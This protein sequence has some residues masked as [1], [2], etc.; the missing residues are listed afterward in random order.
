MKIR[1]HLGHP[2]IGATTPVTKS[3]CR[4]RGT[5]STTKALLPNGGLEQFRRSARLVDPIEKGPQRRYDPDNGAP[6]HRRE[7]PDRG[8]QHNGEPQPVHRTVSP[9]AAPAVR[10]RPWSGSR[11]VWA[12]HQ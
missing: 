11:D 6:R 7:Q 10:N 9:V 1:V 8:P 4:E 12:S 3:P 2:G 5:S